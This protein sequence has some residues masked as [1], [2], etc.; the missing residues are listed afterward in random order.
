MST[1]NIPPNGGK[2]TGCHPEERPFRFGA[3]AVPGL[4]GA[5]KSAPH[6]AYGGLAT[7]STRANVVYAGTQEGKVLCVEQQDFPFRTEA[8]AEV[9]VVGTCCFE[10]LATVSGT[11]D[12]GFS[13]I[14]TFFCL[15]CD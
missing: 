14:I 8:T 7:P 3:V 6:V 2:A 10:H 1:T 9:P 5:V 13:F 4:K 12:K 15:G 11:L